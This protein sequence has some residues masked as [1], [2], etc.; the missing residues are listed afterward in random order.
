[1]F[2]AY[3][4]LIQINDHLFYFFFSSTAALEFSRKVLRERSR[5]LAQRCNTQLQTKAERGHSR[6]PNVENRNAHVSAIKNVGTSR[7]RVKALA[8]PD[9]V[10]SV[11][12]V[13][14]KNACTRVAKIPRTNFRETD[15]A[16]S[17]S[18][19]HAQLEPAHARFSNL[20]R[21]IYSRPEDDRPVECVQITLAVSRAF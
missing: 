8:A 15:E 21:L 6:E 20:L 1:M 18:Y 2:Q 16:S 11:K 17:G 9:T 12:N 5:C 13:R 3:I 19:A 10:R 4:Y 14:A 7:L